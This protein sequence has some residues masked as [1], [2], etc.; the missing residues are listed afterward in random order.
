VA[1]QPETIQST[2][3]GTVFTRE[4]A[5]CRFVDGAWTPH[6]IVPTAPISLHPGAHVLHY[7][8]TCFEGLKA[9]RWSDDS[10][11]VFRPDRHIARMQA[12]TE[13]LCLPAPPTELLRT[14]IEQA[15]DACRDEIP[16]T[17]GALYIRPTL[18]GT[19]TNIGA[20][21]TGSG[22]AC[23]YILLSPVGDYFQGGAR[24]L[25][26]LIEDRHMRT[27][28][29]FGSVK[30]GA[31]YAAALHHVVSARRDH[32]ADQVLFCPGGDVQETGASNFML[33]NDEEIL[34]KPLND[35][36]LHGV[37]RDSLLQLATDLGYRVAERD[38]TVAELLDWIQVGEA[39]L[40][41]TAAVL[42][43]VGT[44]IHAGREIA[45]RNGTVGPNTERLRKA[46][47]DIQTGAAEDRHGWLRSV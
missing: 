20:A 1:A 32:D 8:S 9:Y 24:G 38:F 42:A 46:L 33:L 6:E 37:T 3:F 10:V 30:S 5:I 16:P 15:I 7:A 25:R 34:T 36:F 35:A 43:G 27:A 22:D 13:L 41:G 18:I 29:H 19:D 14:M 31:N 26:I 4:M 44:F 21:G 40:S 45:V 2:P 11:R 17:P 39:A 12:S 47:T 23:L 28:A